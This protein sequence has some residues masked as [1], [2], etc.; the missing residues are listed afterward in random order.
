MFCLKDAAMN[1]KSIDFIENLKTC[2]EMYKKICNVVQIC[3][4]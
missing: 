3:T 4:F 2:F 1:E